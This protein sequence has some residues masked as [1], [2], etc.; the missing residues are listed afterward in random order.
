MTLFTSQK[1]R[2]RDAAFHY[3]Y[4]LKKFPVG[5]D[6]EEQEGEGVSGGGKAGVT[7]AD[8]RRVFKEL[9]VNLLLNLSRC[10]RKLNVSV[11]Y[12]FNNFVSSE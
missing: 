1:N 6:E 8:Q 12:F 5:L 4:A 10:Q 7:E 3:Q 9:R 2:I 11:S